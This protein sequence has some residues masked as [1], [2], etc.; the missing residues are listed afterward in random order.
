MSSTDRDLKMGRALASIPLPELPDGYYARLAEKLD[1]VRPVSSR[2]R[3][4]SRILRMALVAATVAAAAA[5]AAFAVLPAIRG[6]DTA[7]AADMLAS[8][9]SAGPTQTVQ[10]RLFETESAEKQDGSWYQDRLDEDLTLSITGDYRGKT[11]RTEDGG[12][13]STECEFGY[14]AARHELRVARGDSD[15]LQVLQPAWPTDFREPGQDYLGYKAAGASLRALLAQLDPQTQ[16]SE[17]TYLGRPA[18]RATLP[19]VWEGA[20]GWTVTVDKATGLLLE[21]RWSGEGSDGR[22]I[23]H[24][25]RVT[26]FETDV[27]LDAGWQVVPLVEKPTAT[28]RWNYFRD[29]GTRFGDPEAVAERAWPTLPLIPQWAPD[30]YRRVAVASAAYRDPRPKHM[31]DSI[32]RWKVERIRQPGRLPGLTRSK[33]LGPEGAIQGVLVEFRRG[34][35]SFTVEIT[36]RLPDEPG[37][38]GLDPLSRATAEDTVLTDGYLKGAPA[39]TWISSA[40]LP[41]SHV[42]GNSMFVA[43]QGPTLLTYSDRSQ[44]VVYGD[45]TR[46]ELIDVANSLKV[47]GDVERPLPQGY[48]E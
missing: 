27:P 21:R 12:A 47:Y 13:V 40:L 35:D 4:R 22:P 44:I 3:G 7:T 38:H 41:V 20:S 6:T 2:V 33:W 48:G 11:S 29:D 45:L 1:Q 32:W 25:L 18:W 16:V 34:F 28:L 5:V 15:G 31:D 43:F 14:D 24:V 46:Q 37:L 36:P 23:I 9:S 42:D 17:A 39:R 30:G 10:L 26:S 19:S 8:M